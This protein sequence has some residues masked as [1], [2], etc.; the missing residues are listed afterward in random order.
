ML[1]NLEKI[2]QTLLRTGKLN[3]SSHEEYL[4]Q[5]NI[6]LKNLKKALKGTNKP[7][8]LQQAASKINTIATSERNLS[9][10]VVET[11]YATYP[12]AFET[13]AKHENKRVAAILQEAKKQSANT[14]KQISPKQILTA[15]PQKQTLHVGGVHVINNIGYISN[16]WQQYAALL[17]SYIASHHTQNFD[18]L[19]KQY[20]IEQEGTNYY[21]LPSLQLFN[22]DPKTYLR[23]VNKDR[24]ALITNLVR[25][26]NI[27]LPKQKPIDKAMQKLVI[28][29][30]FYK[31]I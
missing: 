4:H 15:M 6:I 29:Q 12:R 30:Y 5:R 24:I 20:C 22:D 14:L 8:K 1:Q 16:N 18:L 27:H 26:Q 11:L 23:K 31:L 21:V 10:I 17:R 19:S 9:E 25:K 28:E 13:K 7:D 2:T 3:V